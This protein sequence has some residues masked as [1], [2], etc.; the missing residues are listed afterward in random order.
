[1]N[2]G[3]N[4][5]ARLKRVKPFNKMSMIA[6]E[7]INSKDFK[8][9]REPVKE[10]EIFLPISG[11]HHHICHKINCFFCSEMERQSTGGKSALTFKSPFR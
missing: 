3:T 6:E 11:A 1:M 4:T 5:T 2:L 10:S 7:K 8:I 9:E